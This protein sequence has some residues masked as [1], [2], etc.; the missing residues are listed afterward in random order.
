MLSYDFGFILLYVAV[1]GLSDYFVKMMNLKEYHLFLYYI[2]TGFIGFYILY[3][4]NYF[5]NCQKKN[6]NI[7]KLYN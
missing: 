2:I 6:S 5:N 3:S 4:S 1:F 7:A